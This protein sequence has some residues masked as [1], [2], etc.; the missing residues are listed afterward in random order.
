M[1]EYANQRPEIDAPYNSMESDD[2]FIIE[3][4][5]SSEEIEE[6]TEHTEVKVKKEKKF[7]K[8][9][10]DTSP[11]RMESIKFYPYRFREGD[12]PSKLLKVNKLDFLF[13][14]GS[15]I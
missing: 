6:Q 13:E 2:D 7:D 1:L 12:I 8:K 5:P 10:L 3:E 14:A 11:Y 9:L 4:S 15:K